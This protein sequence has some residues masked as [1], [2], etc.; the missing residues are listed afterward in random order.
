MIFSIAVHAIGHVSGDKP[1][2]FGVNSLAVEK[3][4]QSDGDYEIVFMHCVRAVFKVDVLLY[5]LDNIGS[6]LLKHEIEL[7]YSVA[8]RQE[9]D[10][11]GD[12]SSKA[13]LYAVLAIDF[14]SRNPGL[15]HVKVHDELWEREVAQLHLFLFFH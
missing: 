3:A 11:D 4:I 8:C 9:N 1:H 10:N 7:E 15:E 14:E 12:H 5:E 6:L 2:I 13:R